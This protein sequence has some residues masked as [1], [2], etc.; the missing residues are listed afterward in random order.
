[1]LLNIYIHEQSALERLRHQQCEGGQEQMLA[2]LPRHRSPRCLAGLLSRCL[3]VLRTSLQRRKLLDVPAVCNRTRDRAP[4]RKDRSMNPQIQA[5]EQLNVTTYTQQDAIEIGRLA[6]CG[7]T[8]EEVLALLWLRH[9][10]QSGG[11][12]RVPLLR[13][14]EFLKQLFIAGKLEV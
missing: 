12:D 3:A 8:A 11:S 7:F 5:E 4:G 13:H 2:D 14:W 10:Y 9:W 1:M 6:Q